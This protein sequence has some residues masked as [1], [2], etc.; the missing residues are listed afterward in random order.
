MHQLLNR[1]GAKD[2]FPGGGVISEPIYLYPP[3]ALAKRSAFEG[4][5]PSLMFL[6]LLYVNT[7]AY[8]LFCISKSRG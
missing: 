7:A 4:G 3:L 2:S 5:F 1:V 8:N 6:P